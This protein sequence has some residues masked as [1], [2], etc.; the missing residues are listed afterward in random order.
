MHAL[1]LGPGKAQVTRKK[2]KKTLDLGCENAYD[3]NILPNTPRHGPL[4]SSF[5]QSAVVG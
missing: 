2:T 5:A 4:I 3:G 1:P